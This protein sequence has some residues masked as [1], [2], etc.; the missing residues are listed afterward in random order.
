M[1]NKYLI[2]ICIPSY[3]RPSGI[4]RLLNSIDTG[5]VNEIQIVICEDM[6]PKRMEVR[7]VVDEYGKSTNYVLKY[8]ENPKNYGHGRNMRECIFQ[9]EG[10]YIMFMGDDDKFISGE[11]DTFF[12]F[13][14]DHQNVGYFLRSYA[15][16][17][18]DDKVEYFKYFNSDMFFEPGLDAYVQFFGK[19]V[20]MS[21]FTIKRNLV[22]DFDISIFDETLLYQLYLVAEVC[23]NHPSAY[24]NTPFAYVVGDGISYFGI[25]EKEKDKYEVG[26]LVSDN[27]NYITGRFKITE[28]IDEKYGIDSTSQI[29]KDTSK[30]CFYMLA[31]SRKFGIFHFLRQRRPFRDA[32]LDKTFYFEIYY[33]SLLIFGRK[34]CIYIIQLIKSILGRRVKL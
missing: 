31:E 1:K 24:Y 28:F 5:Y 22:K 18:A 11:F 7:E 20:S 34:F 17:R 6:A 15:E 25:N 21:G 9:S 33:Y 30:Y 12:N 19:S 14:K 29:K 2:S 16:L 13:V 3:N 4:K 10:D 32:E 27:I 23:L 26:K 8:I